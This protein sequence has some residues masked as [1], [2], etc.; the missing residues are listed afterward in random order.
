MRSLIAIARLARLRLSRLSLKVHAFKSDFW[1]YAV[2][3]VVALVVAVAETVGPCS[4]SDLWSCAVLEEVALVVVAVVEE[5]MVGVVA[6]MAAVVATAT[7]VEAAAAMAAAAAATA[8]AAVTAP[9]RLRH[10]TA[11]LHMEEQTGGSHSEPQA[12]SSVHISVCIGSSRWH[13]ALSLCTCLFRILLIARQESMLN[14]AAG[15]AEH[16]K[17]VQDIDFVITT[18]FPTLP[19]VLSVKA[20]QSAAPYA[21][22]VPLPSSVG[23]RHISVLRTYS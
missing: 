18:A 14:L 21:L 9:P 3:E 22:S 2:A 5:A 6:A 7:V 17:N 4:N 16:A 23:C 15:C 1:F 19:S 20:C 13:S 8:V 11:A 12:L 10:L